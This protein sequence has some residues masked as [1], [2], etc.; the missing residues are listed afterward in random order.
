MGWKHDRG[1]LL[2]WRTTSGAEGKQKYATYREAYDEARNRVKAGGVREV[3][4][5]ED[6]IVARA[7]RD[8]EPKRQPRQVGHAHVVNL[9]ED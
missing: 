2:R 3:W 6:E 1:W 5:C 7:W 8:L 4:V 9:E